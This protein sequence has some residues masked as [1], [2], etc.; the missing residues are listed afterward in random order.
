MKKRSLMLLLVLTLIVSAFAGCGGKETTAG[1]IGDVEVSEPNVFPITQEPTTLSVFVVK[2]PYIEDYATNEFTKAFE[3]KT[4]VKIEWDVATGDAREAF[5]LM[6]ASGKYPDVILGCGLNK[7]ECITY[8]NQGVLIDLK[9]Y[10]DEYGYNLKKAFEEVPDAL[11]SVTLEGKIYGIPDISQSYSSMYLDKMWMYKPWLDKLG[12]DVPTTTDE[13]YDVLK[14]FKEKDPNGNGKADEVPL[15]ARG[16][17]ENWGIK[18]YMMSPFIP[19][20]GTGWYVEDGKV[21]VTAVQEGFKEGLKYLRKL[22]TE[23]LLDPDTFIYDRSQMMALGANEPVILGAATGQGPYMFNVQGSATYNDYIAVPPLK[24]PD[25]KAAA[26]KNTPSYF[27]QFAVTSSCKNPAVAVKWI[28]YFYSSEGYIAAIQDPAKQVREATEGEKGL[29]GQQALYAIDKVD[30][31]ASGNAAMAQNKVW[32]GLQ[33]GYSSYERSTRTCDYNATDATRELYRAHTIYEPHS[34]DN[35]L[36]DLPISSDN[37]A[38]YA[39]LHLSLYN[40][41]NTSFT[42]FVVGEMDI[43]KDWDKYIKNLTSIG[44]DRYVELLQQGYDMQK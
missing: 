4:N 17:A 44:F 7:S 41:M 14:A 36:A 12:L 24:G 31:A 32:K 25:G 39:E 20:G 43:E 13:F 21:K 26:V 1:L 38:E 9:P 11:R 18:N 30:A 2:G 27:A 42:K 19:E 8:G 5:N 23:G 3:E 22:Y 28:D 10:I 29:D 40:E 33:I 37:A 15:A 6:M 16:V 35:F 34:V